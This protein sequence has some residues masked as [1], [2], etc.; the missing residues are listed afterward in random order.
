MQKQEQLL[1]HG[2]LHF[3]ELHVMPILN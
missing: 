1:P 2:F 3:C